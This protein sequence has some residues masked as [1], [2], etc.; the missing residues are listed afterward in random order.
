MFVDW[1]TSGGDTIPHDAM[2]AVP[3]VVLRVII[4]RSIWDN[5]TIALII[6]YPLQR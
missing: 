3:A 4:A 1:Y 5:N 2:I 6:S